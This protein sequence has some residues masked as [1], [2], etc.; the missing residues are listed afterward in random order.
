M[1]YKETPYGP[2][3]SLYKLEQTYVFCVVFGRCV[4]SHKS[5]NVGN[6]ADWL[7]VQVCHA[8]D[9]LELVQY[10][11]DK[12]LCR[13]TGLTASIL[14]QLHIS[15]LQ[16]CFSRTKGSHG[17][18]RCS[19]LSEIICPLMLLDVPFLFLRLKLYYSYEY[20]NF[21]LVFYTMKNMGFILATLIDAILVVV[22]KK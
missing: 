11:Q 1:G 20:I 5:I 15:Q 7:F 19:Q 18:N 12:D 8:A 4:V 3:M 9:M 2:K 6:L 16:L 17:R 22:Y 14:C 13:K 21:Q 10:M